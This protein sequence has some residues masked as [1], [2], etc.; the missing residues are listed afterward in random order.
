M[1][2]VVV[3]VAALACAVLLELHAR[4][5]RHGVGNPARD[6]V[7]RALLVAVAAWGVLYWTAPTSVD[8]AVYN[9]Q[10]GEPDF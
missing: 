5:S 10:L 1:T 9:M 2:F 8:D 3:V 7:V 4:S 6:F